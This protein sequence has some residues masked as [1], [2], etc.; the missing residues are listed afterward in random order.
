MDNVQ[1]Y[2]AIF[3]LI[4]FGVTLFECEKK[5]SVVD[6]LKWLFGM[7]IYLPVTGRIFGWW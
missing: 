6:L 4:G 5:G 7:F 1:M 2:L 3:F